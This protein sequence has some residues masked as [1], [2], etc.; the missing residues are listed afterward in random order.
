MPL[1]RQAEAY[2][3]HSSTSVHRNKTTQTRW[4]VL[5][6]TI[7]A[8]CC[9]QTLELG[10]D[11]L[12]RS[13]GGDDRHGEFATFLPPLAKIAIVLDL[14]YSAATPDASNISGPSPAPA[15]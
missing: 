11:A 8:G 1:A 2:T 12:A 14:H 3:T 15:P 7:V 10:L 5:R 9:F 4:V 6:E 13:G